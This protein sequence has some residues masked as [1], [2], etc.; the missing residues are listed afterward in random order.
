MSFE[1]SSE[2]MHDYTFRW[3]PQDHMRAQR[4][5]T[6][7]MIGGW[8]IKVLPVAILALIALLAI[9]ILVSPRRAETALAALPYALILGLVL[10]LLRWG[11]PWLAARRIARYDPSVKG[12]L[13]HSTSDS[14]FKIRTV[15]ATV[16][17]TWDHVNQVVETS[18]FFLYYYSRQC[19]YFTPKR[20]I[21]VT[22]LDAL[23]NT[24]RSHVGDRAR[25]LGIVP[26]AA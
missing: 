11:T 4:D 5:M 13:R 15:A 8:W 2:T 20:A 1:L 12:D 24:I 10:V 26:P 9:S 7:H 6:R 19:A 18:E 16:D 17:L 23:R 21:P 25:L 22:D 3:T 14:G